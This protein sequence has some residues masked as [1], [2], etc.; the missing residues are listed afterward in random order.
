MSLKLNNK[1]R[2]LSLFSYWCLIP[3]ITETHILMCFLCVDVRVFT[4]IC[5]IIY[6]VV[7]AVRGSSVVLYN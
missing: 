4:L 7:W 2:E 6:P 3:C 1:D 5:I